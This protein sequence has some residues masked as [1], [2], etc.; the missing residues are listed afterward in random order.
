MTLL[1]IGVQLGL[2][3]CWLSTNGTRAAVPSAVLS[4]VAS[5]GL[6]FLSR[7]EHSRSVRPSFILSIYLLVSV[8]VDALQVRTLFLRHDK[9][10]IVGL[11]TANVAI[12]SVLLVLESKSKREHLRSPY[13]S[14]PPEL[15]SGIY[16]RSFFW[17]INP[18]LVTGF[19]ELIT[20]DDLF[21]IDTSLNSEVLLVEIQASWSKCK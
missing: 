17:W 16:N 18:L 5:F 12:K 2:V 6:L 14:Y 20:L 11:S 3:I 9:P 7:L 21:V 8:S 19:R 1:L 15:T 4:F 10:A 13:K